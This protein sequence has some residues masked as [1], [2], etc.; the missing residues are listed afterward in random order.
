MGLQKDRAAWGEHLWPLG[1]PVR[2][3]PCALGSFGFWVLP[4]KFLV[5]SFP[6]KFMDLFDR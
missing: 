1:G 5:L 3:Q 4:H 6:G 2:S